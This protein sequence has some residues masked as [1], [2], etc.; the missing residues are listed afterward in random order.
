M[1]FFAAIICLIWFLFTIFWFKTKV[2]G[3]GFLEKI[4]AYIVISIAI[5]GGVR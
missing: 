2:N 4:F 5:L 3:S 1:E